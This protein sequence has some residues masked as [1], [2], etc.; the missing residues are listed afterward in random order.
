[1]TLIAESAAQLTIGDAFAVLRGLV[2]APVHVKC[3]ALCM[4]GSIKIK[5]ALRM[6]EALEAA[7]RIGPDSVLI[8]SSSGNLGV[9]L[10]IVAAAKGYRFVCVTDPVS[11]PTNRKLMLAY[12][13]SIIVVDKRDRNGG[14][15]ATRI[16]L[17]NEMCARDPRYVWVNQYENEDNWRSHYF[18]TAP[19]ILASF[20]K[21]DWLFV[22]AGTTGTLMGCVRY[23]REHSPQT[24][25]IA[26]DSVGSVTFGGAP[27]SRKIPGLGTSR[28]PPIFNPVEIQRVVMVPEE[29]AIR[30]CRSLARRG[31]LFGGSTGTVLAGVCS[32]AA[33]IRPDDIVVAPSPDFGERYLDSIYDDEWIATHFP[34]A[35]A[36]AEQQQAA[37]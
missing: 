26:V 30:M 1:M 33:E 36:A 35:I 11:S 20:P 18:A 16:E 13:A 22:G 31:F 2:S 32:C 34:N 19:E 4:A 29:L 23:F 12:G 27:G 3:E 24:R 37:E 9:A 14:F 6:V 17:I 7:D 15:L 8:E 21:T 28:V 25:I 5:P 10:S